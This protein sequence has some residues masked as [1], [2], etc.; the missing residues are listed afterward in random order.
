MGRLADLRHS[1]TVAGLVRPAVRLALL[2]GGLEEGTFEALSEPRTAAEL[3]EETSTDREL[4][5]AWLRAA[6]AA[7]L[8]E[9]RGN[10]YGLSSFVRWL[11]ETKSGDAGRAL[12]EQAIHSY[13]PV[14]GRYQQIIRCDARPIWRDDLKGAE[15]VSR[16]SRVVGRRAIRALHRVPGVRSARRVLD[17]GCGEGGYL[18]EL[19]RRHRDAIGDGVELDAGVAARARARLQ[20]GGVHR[21]AEIH[22]GDFTTLELPHVAYDLVLLN[23]NVYYFGEDQR[24]P[25]FR[26]I[27]DHLAPAGVLAIQSPIVSNDPVSRWMGATATIA[28]FDAF[29]RIHEDLAGLPEPDEL[30]AQLR[31]AG[32]GEIGTES[33]VPGGS[34]RYVWA[35]KPG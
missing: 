15:R 8:L 11:L 17:V 4:T 32:F 33:I 2:R 31:N 20:A 34:I 16:A 10:A 30:Q 26:R 1:A 12:L 28:S 19:L 35:R 24:E 27:L 22:V 14:L 29:L 25:L 7:G 9:L 13:G 5:A 6:E 3:A 18:L 23:N 21:R